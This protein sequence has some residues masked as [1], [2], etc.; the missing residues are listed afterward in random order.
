MYNYKSH[1]CL[2]HMY[3]ISCVRRNERSCGKLVCI[4]QMKNK[5]IRATKKIT[6]FT[7]SLLCSCTKAILTGHLVIKLID[8][9][10]DYP[11]D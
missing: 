3:N 9:T 10:R 8:N 4:E 11:T 7:W 6:L 1:V 2:Q 5:K